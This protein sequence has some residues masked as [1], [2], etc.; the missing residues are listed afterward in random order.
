MPREI[1]VFI[2]SN[3]YLPEMV[4]TKSEG[5]VGLI[6]LLDG[7]SDPTKR[8]EKIAS[9]RKKPYPQRLRPFF[10]CNELVQL[11]SSVWKI[12]SL[13]W[14]TPLFNPDFIRMN[15]QNLHGGVSHLVSSFRKVSN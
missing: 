8:A 2:S 14:K 12:P 6:S 11:L 10:Q 7:L 9:F 1:G 3:R 4:E 13:R 5:L 15:L